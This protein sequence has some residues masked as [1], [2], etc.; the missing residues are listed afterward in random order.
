MQEMTTTNLQ[1]P[2]DI[3]SVIEEIITAHN[4][5]RI[6]TLKFSNPTIWQIIDEPEPETKKIYIQILPKNKLK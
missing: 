4:E 3:K 1:V 6:K 2:T 5:N